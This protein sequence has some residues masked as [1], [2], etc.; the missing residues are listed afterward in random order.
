MKEDFELPKMSKTTKEKID[1]I[2][3]TKEEVSR[4]DDEILRHLQR[5]S[6]K[7][8]EPTPTQPS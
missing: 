1:A 8:A 4:F 2:Q 6:K 3:L 5:H 7:K